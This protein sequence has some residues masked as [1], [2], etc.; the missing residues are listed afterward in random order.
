MAAGSEAATF[1]P[2]FIQRMTPVGEWTDWT[3]RRALRA[4]RPYVHARVGF[5]PWRRSALN[6]HCPLAGGINPTKSPARQSHE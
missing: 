3:P 1:T 4:D 5:M 6:A 2:A